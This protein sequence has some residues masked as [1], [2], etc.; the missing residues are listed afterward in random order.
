MKK[1]CGGADFKTLYYNFITRN[2]SGR[3]FIMEDYQ[4]E[5]VQIG[6]GATIII[7]KAESFLLNILKDWHDKRPHALIGDIPMFFNTISQREKKFIKDKILKG[8]EKFERI[9]KV[10]LQLH[11]IL[12]EHQG[13]NKA[14]LSELKKDRV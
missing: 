7:E 1:Y 10:A 2:T 14:R 5:S 9:P 11:N 6:A 13:L 8:K 12:R 3:I 4:T